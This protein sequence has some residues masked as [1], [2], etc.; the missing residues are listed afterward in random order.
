V[1]VQHVCWTGC[2]C[3]V[4]GTCT[5]TSPPSFI[6]ISRYVCGHHYH[7]CLAS[8]DVHLP[9]QAPDGLCIAL[10]SLQPGNVLIGHDYTAKIGDFGL[11]TLRRSTHQ[12]TKIQSTTEF[13]APEFFTSASVVHHDEKVGEP[14]SVR[15][16]CSMELAGQCK[17]LRVQQCISC[18]CTIDDLCSLTATYLG[19]VCVARRLTCSALGCCCMRW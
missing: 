4:A 5:T 10:L 13:M 17:D 1:L 6:G 16:S 12:S 18:S 8:P 14:C 3:V 2:C 19:I 15:C 7:T 9:L 11:S